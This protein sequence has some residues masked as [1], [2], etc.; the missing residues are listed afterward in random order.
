MGKL[1]DANV[2]LRYILNDSQQSEAAKGVIEKGAYTIPEVIAEVVYVLNGVYHVARDEIAET[3]CTVL[4]E[5]DI[6]KFEAMVEALRLYGETNMDF[7]DCILIA[8]HRILGDDVY[9]FD[10]QINKYID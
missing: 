1:I 10:K 2:I 7:V 5:I 6:E 8:R 9:S 3:L 4:H